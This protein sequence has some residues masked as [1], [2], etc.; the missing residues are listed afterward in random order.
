MKNLILNASAPN[1]E[2]A[3]GAPSTLCENFFKQS[4]HGSAHL[5]FIRALRHEF[6]AQVEVLPGVITSIFNGGFTWSHDDSPRNFSVFSF[7][8]KRIFSKNA[9]TNCIVLQL[10]E[11]AGRGLSNNNVK[12]ALKQGIEIL[13]SI[14]LMKYSFLNTL[15]A[16]KFLFWLELFVENLY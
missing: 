5:T 9:M 6:S 8:E 7:P 13:Q 3:A 14:E 1:S 11:I 15:S 16:S 4:S 2:V 12:E 10:K